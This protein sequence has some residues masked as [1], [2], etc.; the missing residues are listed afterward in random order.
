[1]TKAD[2]AFG[3][4]LAALAAESPSCSGDSLYTADSVAA[5]ELRSLQK[6]C[7]T[8]PVFIQ[9]RSYALLARPPAGIWAGES[10]AV[11]KPSG[12]PRKV[13]QNATT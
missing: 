2:D 6:I 12:R 4:L 13:V 8:C 1:M 7:A 11:K 10:W 5:D 3:R 9:C